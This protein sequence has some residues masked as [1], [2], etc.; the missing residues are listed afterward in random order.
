[1]YF[2]TVNMRTVVP[3]GYCTLNSFKNTD[4]WNLSYKKKSR[5][6]AESAFLTSILLLLEQLPYFKKTD[7]RGKI[8]G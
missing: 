2:L 6:C 1:M 4:F 7:F 8:I 5:K 3:T